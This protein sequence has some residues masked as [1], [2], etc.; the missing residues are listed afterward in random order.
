MASSLP[1][2]WAI[3]TVIGTIYLQFFGGGIFP[4]P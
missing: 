4:T 2:R 3:V 1:G